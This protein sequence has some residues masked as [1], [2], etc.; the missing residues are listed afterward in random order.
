MVFFK[1]VNVLGAAPLSGGVASLTTAMPKTAGIFNITAVFGGD[2]LF[3]SSGSPVLWQTVSNQSQLPTTTALAS[4]L[5]PSIYGQSITLTAFITPSS[6]SVSSPT[7]RVNFYDGAIIVGHAFLNAKRLASIT[8][9]FLNA[10]QH[11]LL[12][13]YVGD[14]DNG[15]SASSTLS[16]SVEPATTSAT[17]A[18]SM[19]PQT[20]GQPV[21]FTVRIASP[22]LT[23]TG[24]ATFQTGTTVLGM[25][26]LSGGRAT[27]TVL[28]LPVG[29]TKITVSYSGNSNIEGSSA[30][31][32]QV[33][34]P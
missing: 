12:A 33:V 21:T 23:P 17:I 14:S 4:T 2:S 22:T 34:N 8:Q 27:L 13:V 31:I 24:P 20:E 11:S 6:G 1:G 18:S 9:R 25:A 3:A 32:T 15:A 26:Q 19:N 5:D 28:S 10:G 29:S 16:Q 7:G 30:S